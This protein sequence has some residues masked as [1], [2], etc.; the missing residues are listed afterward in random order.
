[1]SRPFQKIGVDM[2]KLARNF[3]ESVNKLVV[4]AAAQAGKYVSGSVVNP[5]SNPI[6]TGLS[7][8]NWQADIGSPKT[9]QLDRFYPTESGSEMNWLKNQKKKSGQSFFISNSVD[10]IKTIINHGTITRVAGW[11]GRAMRV[12][13]DE[14][15]KKAKVLKNG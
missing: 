5:N 14:I 11:A 8:G 1:M 15:V 12:G 4:D 7:S 9:E 10:Y 13:A 2:D 3:E 6:D